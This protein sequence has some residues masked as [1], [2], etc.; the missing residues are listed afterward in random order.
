MSSA[1]R[2]ESVSDYT[3]FDFA[4]L[5]PGREKVTEVERRFLAE[6]LADADRR[7]ILEVGSGFG[8]LLSAVEA[9]A[10]EVVAT[11]FDLDS[12]AR[13]PTTG[14]RR[15]RTRRVAANVYHLPFA[16][17]SFTAATMVRVYHHLG[18][19]RAVLA[20]LRRVL[21]PGGR[22]LVSYNPTPTVGTLV[23]DIQRALRPS[24]RVPFRSITFAR[25]QHRQ[26]PADPFPVY[27]GPREEFAEF[28]GTTGFHPR[29]EMVSGLEE[30]YLMRF[31]PTDWFVRIG[32]ALGRAPG[33]P[34]RFAV[35]ESA[36]GPARPL[37]AAAEIW[38]CPRC[39]GAIPQDR[40]S[41]SCARCG[42]VG[43]D[44]D[45]VADLRYV[46]EGVPRWSGGSRA[47]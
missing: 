42:V 19:P 33:F 18:D 41:F 20:E 26:L 17:G 43:R 32:V 28:A 29:R 8:R 6:G 40:G 16:D 9:E 14:V 45:G 7:R 36:P 21:V 10:E 2:S 34:M 13:I 39:H 31:V 1:A 37:P 22:L 4:A 46:P 23:N 27:V 35:L 12:L 38:A 15:N 47:G 25:G 24:E 30:Y 44:R 3:G 11:D 5:W